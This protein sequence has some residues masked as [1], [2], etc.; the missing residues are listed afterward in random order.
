MFN[1][2]KLLYLVLFYLIYRI[3]DVILLLV[4]LVQTILNI[5]SGEPS[6]SIKSFGKSLGIYLKQIS[7]FL[8]YASE[9]KPFPFSDW[10]ELVSPSS[11]DLPSAEDLES[12]PEDATLNKPVSNEHEGTDVATS[13]E[14]DSK[15][16]VND[17]KN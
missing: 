6:D 1:V 10:P 11:E 16:P 15:P 17:S 5:F 12:E 9:E 2:I 14:N 3:T 7:E 4:L 8:S 13:N